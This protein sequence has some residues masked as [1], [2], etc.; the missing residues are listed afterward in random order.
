MDPQA[1]GP[2]KFRSLA[3]SQSIYP[4]TRAVLDCYVALFHNGGHE[5]RALRQRC[6]HDDGSGLPARLTHRSGGVKASGVGREG[7]E[8]SLDFF[9]EPVNVC[10]KI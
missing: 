7:G 3:I 8:Y 6:L 9:S 1:T 2:A 4:A 10:V 5:A